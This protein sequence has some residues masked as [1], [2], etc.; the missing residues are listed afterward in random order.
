M[1]LIAA[2]AQVNYTW[3]GA[4]NS[5]WNN[6]ANWTPNTGFPQATDNATIPAG[7]GPVLLDTP[8]SVNNL[9]VSTGTVNLNGLSLTVTGNGAFSNGTMNNGT[10]VLNTAGS[11]T[12]SGTTFNAAIQGNSANV[13]FN[14]SVFNAAVRI[15]KTGASSNTCTGGSTFNSLLELSLSSTADWFV[16]NNNNDAYNGDVL[17]NCTS[18][19]SIRFG[20]GTGGATLAAG[21]NIAAGT[22]GFSSGRLY[23]LDF[24]QLGSTAQN[25]NLSGTA[26]LYLRPGTIFNAALNVSAPRVFMDGGTYNA[27]TNITQTGAIA[28]A[29]AG[30]CVFNAS[31][32]LTCTGAG[33]LRLCDTGT[34]QYN[35]DLVLNNT[36]AGIRFGNTS[37]TGN[38]AA[39]RTITIGSGGFS[40]GLLLL[41]NF[42]Q[43]GSTA[44]SLNLTGTS[45]LYFRPGTSFDGA[46]TVVAPR[47]QMDGGTYNGNTDL[48]TTSTTGSAGAGGCTFNGTLTLTSS[49]AGELQLCDTGT[50]Q[51]NGDI[52]VNCPGGGG[53]RF[54]NNSGTAVLA[55]GRTISVGAGGFNSGLLLLKG[56]QQLGN[57][58]QAITLTGTAAFYLRTN[59]VFNADLQA[60]APLLF[61]DGGTY[62]GTTRLLMT[63]NTSTGGVGGCTFNG[64]LDIGTTG[65]GQIYLCT[66]FN[67]QYNGNVTVNCT[68]GGGVR[69]GNSTGIGTL[70]AGRTISVGSG[71]FD[72]GLLLLRGF[73]QV[74]STPQTI[75]LSG[76]ADLY[77]RTGTVFDGTLDATAAR[78]YLEGGTY[79][80]PSRFTMSG[81]SWASG[82]GGCTFNASVELT[83]LGSGVMQLHASS[84]DLFNGDITVN[85]PAGAGGF[86]FGGTS[87]AGTLAAGRTITVGPLGFQSGTLQFQNFTQTGPTPQSLVMSGTSV[88]QFMTGTTFNGALTT[89]SPRVGF[90]GATFND[91][92]NTTMNGNYAI[93]SNG[94]NTFNSTLE[95]TVSGGADLRMYVYNDDIYAG[96]VRVNSIGGGALRFGLGNTVG[97]GTLAAGRTISV[98]SG[99]FDAGV[100]VLDN[101]IQNGATPQTLTTTGSSLL[102][103]FAG[104]VWNGDLTA[105]APRLFLNGGLYQGT[106]SFTKTGA[107]SDNGDGGNTFNG[108]L[109]LIVTG[110]GELRMHVLNNDAYNS[111][112][113]VS[114]IGGAGIRFGT[115]TSAGT[116][117]LA[118]GSTITV[119]PGG[120]DAGLLLFNN[121]IQLGATAQTLTTTG[122][123]LMYFYTGTV[124]NG[125]L[126]ASAPRMFLNG[127]RFEG[128]TSITKTAASNDN[129]D[130]GNI[131][132][133]VLDLVTTGPGEMRMHV[134]NNDAYNNN[135][136]VAN[137]SGGGI[138]FGT[139]SSAGI[140]TLAA[141][142]SITI[143]AGGFNAG[144]LSFNNFKQ[145]GTVPHSLTLTGTA[146]L[147]FFTGTLFEAAIVT[148]SPRL[149]LNGATFQG[150]AQFTKSG[151]V[152][153][154]S[155]GGNTFNGPTE[156][157][158][159]ATG[160]IWLHATG[161]DQFNNDVRVNSTSTGG[162]R[163][164]Q[165]GGN[166]TLAAGRTIAVGSL[167]FTGGLL[168]FR[169]FA[170]LGSAS[171]NT[172]ACTGS[173]A[174]YFQSGSSFDAALTTTSGSLFF[175][176][177]TFNG[178][179]TC[180]KTGS[181]TDLSTG[182]NTFNGTTDLIIQG[183][184]V[185]QLENTQ[186]DVFNADLRVSCNG[187]GGLQF[188]V[189]TGTA[190]LASGR[191]ITI[192]A[193][194]FT[195]GTLNLRNFTQLGTTAQNI[196]MASAGSGVLQIRT[197][198]TFNGALTSDT[199]GLLLDGGTF[200]GTTIMTKRG[201]GNNTSRGGNTFNA[202]ARVVGIGTGQIVLANNQPDLFND[203][204][205]FV[206]SSSGA[207][208]VAYTADATFMKNISLVGSTGIIQFGQNNGKTIISGSGDR[209]F[210][211][212]AA[213]PP[214]V[215][216]LRMNTSSGGKLLL[217]VTMDIYGATEFIS[218]EI[219]AAAATSTSNGLVRF[220]NT[221]SFPT[222]A[223]AG[224]FVDGFVRKTGNT[225]FTFP[226]GDNGIY[227]PVAISAPGNT[228]HHF[229]ARYVDVDAAPLYNDQLKDASIDHIS[230][231]EY[232]IVDRTN[233]TS[234]V[235][236]TLSWEAPR[237]CGVNAPA[238]L[239][240]ARWNGS[241]WK[242]HGNGG[243]TGSNPAGT[244]T[245]AA[246]VTSFS[247]FTLASHFTNNPLPV[248]LLFF[249]ARPTG[250]SVTCTW[251][252]ASEKDNDHFEVQ[253]SQVGENF[254]SIGSIEGAGNSQAV[255]DYSFEDR[256]PLQGLSYYRLKQV[257]VDGTETLSAIVAVHREGNNEL[258]FYPNPAS[259]EIHLNGTAMTDPVIQAN[260]IDM[261]GR[262]VKVMNLSG[263]AWNAPITITDL[264][265][266]VYTLRVTGADGTMQEGRFL[267]H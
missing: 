189:N 249:R 53:I 171:P 101:F 12:F 5:A 34:D 136:R 241:M 131:F 124:F 86:V 69:F 252:T 78:V 115:G 179:L 205:E 244:I 7:A 254:I 105:T 13:Y 55:A 11:C 257:D 20:W 255:L 225:A 97:S 250:T 90:H 54:G 209:S 113:R 267:K 156:F 152:D 22:G 58:P 196:T 175:N 98:G 158:S 1:A 67:D 183:N 159:T 222:P 62:Q 210:N 41:K 259:D 26:E 82:A 126:A 42:K 256:A 96:D 146:V 91:A 198:T 127:G 63:G 14:G 106:S 192:G 232:W 221:C 68:G 19:G 258:S 191:T 76:T 219:H 145:L 45:I 111:N 15:T 89:V 185:L 224:S 103:F 168:L 141:G 178:T 203:D 88:L 120:F 87:G 33:E 70:A 79:N 122:T 172:L 233:G 143:G 155:T 242:D 176:G 157:I 239:V 227:A 61:M 46:L 186:P 253:R 16:A 92:V 213:F 140:G 139:G 138:R 217:N 236:V 51:Y 4:A 260:I 162:I 231:C 199:P 73:Q 50:D 9:T 81:S 110:P 223:N 264:P 83:T 44:Q 117:T 166:G 38:L 154:A 100:L 262:Q 10:L 95:L 263:S 29:G 226:V 202:P 116:G 153:D 37:G 128:A 31:L 72:S 109:D 195:N 77:F 206:R 163:F 180:T 6:N 142:S 74:G 56:F 266:G 107:G 2:H 194:G 151:A 201:A 235:S 237:S 149:Y 182:G 93:N 243:W 228:T 39:T 135:V 147:T 64:P 60:T 121:F 71:G 220:A 48:T 27:T 234:N 47:I 165:N 30:G 164:G 75:A 59:C 104:S 177:T 102:Y 208:H 21:R 187:T 25:I 80:A 123:S 52:R 207:M 261:E 167:G 94:G 8:R 36:G 119:G 174:L 229:T 212:V 214:N 160:Q 99:G 211:G 148:S 216:N 170:Q 18:T 265:A 169:N 35:G 230:D 129:S 112:V 184:G 173:S 24:V 137:I 240:V 204:A 130:G 125:D 114:S 245:T 85:A 238:D 150:T 181:A 40:A 188:G 84:T 43:L 193:G 218:G 108:P 118:A 32:E 65:T 66:Q 144:N 57:T 23:L 215:R 134:I 197:G 161:T 28:S 247:P 17:V 190:T 200:N 246:A 251:A 49:A 3:T 248:E 133:G 132:N